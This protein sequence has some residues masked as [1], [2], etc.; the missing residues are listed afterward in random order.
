MR[1]RGQPRPFLGGG[2]I[3]RNQQQPLNKQLEQQT[4]YT[5]NGKQDPVQEP[6]AQ[7]DAKTS[8]E[9]HGKEDA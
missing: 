7:V 3:P 1:N 9:R 8:G 2:L 5:W 6:R 4:G